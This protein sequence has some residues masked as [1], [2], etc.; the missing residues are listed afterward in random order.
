MRAVADRLGMPEQEVDP[1]DAE[2]AQLRAMNQELLKR[3]AALEAE[4]A[5]LRKNSSNSSKPPSSDI[6]KPF[7]SSRSPGKRPP[8][9][10]PGHPRHERVMVPPERVDRVIR[11]TLRDCPKGHGM[12]RPARRPPRIFQ[13]LG[14]VEKPFVVTEWRA[15]AYWC[16]GCQ[17]FHS[18]HQ[19]GLQIQGCRRTP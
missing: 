11:C 14:L 5:R 6:V 19:C 16:P 13:Q 7:A 4:L 3:V 8:G 17:D 10:Q 15:E 9:G 12:L 2:I 18:R 1:R